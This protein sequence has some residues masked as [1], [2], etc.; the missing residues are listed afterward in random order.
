M[1]NVNSDGIAVNPV[2][3]AVEQ[4]YSSF[5]YDSLFLF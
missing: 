1:F 3:V 2:E 5:D 4:I